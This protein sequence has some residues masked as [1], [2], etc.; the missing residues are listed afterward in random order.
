M[1]E[2]KVTDKVRKPYCFIADCSSKMPDDKTLIVPQI[3]VNGQLGLPGDLN[4][5]KDSKTN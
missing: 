3:S 2:T 1:Y 5:D 4:V